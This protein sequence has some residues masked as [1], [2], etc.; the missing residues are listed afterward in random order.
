MS[1]T[2]TV[3]TQVL[4]ERCAQ[5]VKWGQ[6]NHPDVCQTLMTRGGFTDERGRYWPGGCTPERMAQHYE[7]PSAT[8]AK[9]LTDLAAQRG[10]IT[11]ADIM[12]EEVAEA[13]EAATL[14]DGNLRTELIQVAAVAVAWV[15]KIDRQAKS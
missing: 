2:E 10:V 5:E 11:Y 6:Q 9:Y 4:A 7:I 15:E 8:R 14:R 1:A 12:I 13:I 3:L